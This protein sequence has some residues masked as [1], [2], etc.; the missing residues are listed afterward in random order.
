MADVLSHQ[1]IFH[2]LNS[3]FVVIFMLYFLTSAV[4]HFYSTKHIGSTHKKAK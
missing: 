3:R 2:L 4:L 1:K